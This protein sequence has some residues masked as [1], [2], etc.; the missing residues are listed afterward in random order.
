[1]VLSLATVVIETNVSYAIY[2]A[3][4]FL[5]SMSEFITTPLW[6][7]PIVWSALKSKG[8]FAHRVTGNCEGIQHLLIL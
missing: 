8:S 1:M 5:Y 6:V 7:L 4:R 3:D 2:V